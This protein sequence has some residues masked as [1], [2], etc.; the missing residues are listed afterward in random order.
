MVFLEPREKPVE[1]ESADGS[2]EK[3]AMTL[4]RPAYAH[5]Q[6][7]LAVYQR[8]FVELASV[9]EHAT[10]REQANATAAYVQ[11]L[12]PAFV[13][14][15]FSEYVRNVTGFENEAGPVTL[16]GAQLL[17]QVPDH[18]LVVFVLTSLRVM[19]RLGKGKSSRSSSASTS[20]PEA[21][22]SPS[23]AEPTEGCDASAST[24]APETSS[25]SDPFSVVA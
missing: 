18:A 24:T 21:A 12:P 14:T 6:E 8:A 22:Q 4:V 13:E 2:G 11:A 9:D 17:K 19:C 20:E 3:I 10:L 5:A 7:L 1:Y 15:L 25:E 23:T 16:T